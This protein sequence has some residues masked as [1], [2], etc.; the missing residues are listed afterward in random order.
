MRL[1]GDVCVAG[2]PGGSDSEEP[3]C[4]AGDLGYDPWVG[5]IPPGEGN[6]YALLHSHVFLPGKF[7]F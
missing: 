4:N 6:G 5:E 1:W 7:N 2:D 3:A